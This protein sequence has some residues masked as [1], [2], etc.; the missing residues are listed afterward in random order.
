MKRFVSFIEISVVALTLAA[1]GLV[2]NVNG[3]GRSPAIEPISPEYLDGKLDD[4]VIDGLIS[5]TFATSGGISITADPSFFT[6]SADDEENLY[7]LNTQSGIMW[8]VDKTG[9]Y[10]DE[11]SGDAG[12]DV[13][14]SLPTVDSDFSSASLRQFNGQVAMMWWDTSWNNN[15]LTFYNPFTAGLRSSFAASGDLYL[16]FGLT[17]G[18][19]LTQQVLERSND[20]SLFV[21]SWNESDTHIQKFD[22]STGAYDTD[23]CSNGACVIKVYSG[24]RFFDAGYTMG[25][26]EDESVLYLLSHS[27]ADNLGSLDLSTSELHLTKINPETGAVISTPLTIPASDHGEFGWNGSFASSALVTGSHGIYAVGYG[28]QVADFMLVGINANESQMLTDI[29]PDGVVQLGDIIKNTLPGYMPFFSFVN[30]PNLVQVRDN[31]I[32]VL[33]FGVWT[34]TNGGTCPVVTSIDAD[35]G[36]VRVIYAGCLDATNNYN[37]ALAVGKEAIYLMLDVNAMSA[38]KTIQIY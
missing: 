17:P 2:I 29:E 26:S 19:G 38:L 14:A 31:V 30:T 15:Y 24:S 25:L 5:P 32:Y 20:N 16:G 12:I 3:P 22:L 37:G 1:C 34:A 35:T 33:S 11:W 21:S 6:I 36:Q 10:R 27:A 7:V 18:S 8:S 23:F 9:S 4:G 13:K 28:A